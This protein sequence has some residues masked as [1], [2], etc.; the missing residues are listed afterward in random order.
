M[1]NKKSVLFFDID[2]T[3]Y[4]GFTPL[5]LAVDECKNGL[6]SQDDLNIIMEDL[7]DYKKGILSYE[8]ASENIINHYVQITKGKKRSDFSK[9]AEKFFTKNKNKFYPF[10]SQ[11][12][13]KYQK[14]HNSFF[15]S[16]GF[17]YSVEIVCRM[18][19]LTG[20]ICN[21]ITTQNDIFQGELITKVYNQQDK[22]KI[23]EK[24]ML[25]YV[26]K[27]SVGFG[28]SISDAGIMNS[29]QNAICVNPSQ[30]LQKLAKE[31]EWIISKPEEVIINL[32][33][34]L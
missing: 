21:E 27:G 16:S 12:I 14:T 29:C 23:V 20:F 31:K 15:I 13:S 32:E 30:E 28:D 5:E 17:D 8:K 4:D 3:C 10:L 7:N 9:N 18:F 26:W 34:L 33:R 19:G 25:D 22:E 1:E 11:V 24:I 2:N 6:I